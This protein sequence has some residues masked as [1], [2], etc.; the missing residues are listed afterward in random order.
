[1]NQRTKWI[2]RIA[3]VAL[4]SLVVLGIISYMTPGNML[5]ESPMV[6]GKYQ[7]SSL[8]DGQVEYFEGPVYFELAKQHSGF[9]QI[10]VFKLHFIN[11]NAQKGKGFGFIIPLSQDS[12]FIRAEQ[13]SVEST[14]DEFL[15]SLGTVFGYAD[16][17]KEKNT[18]YFTESGSISIS[19]SSFE[20]VAGNMNMLLMDENGRSMR[21]KGRFNAR[22]LYTQQLN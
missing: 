7:L 14:K 6:T 3:G 13:Y 17:V 1:M 8:Q 4:T 15:S 11:P 21:L 22:P 16:L 12:A 18:L 5:P 20:E 10:P 9:R 2:T 19:A